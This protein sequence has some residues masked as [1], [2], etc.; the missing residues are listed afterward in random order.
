MRLQVQAWPK[1]RIRW[2]L[3]LALAFGALLGLMVWAASEHALAGAA[4]ALLV[5]GGFFLMATR[6]Y[7]RRRRLLAQP[8]PPDWREALERRVQFYARLDEAGRRRFEDD[9]RIFLNE[10]RI[11]GLRG[12]KVSD[13]SRVLIAA[14]AATMSHG[15]P[16][17]EWPTMRDI[18]VYPRRFDDEYRQEADAGILGMVHSQGPFLISER[19]LKEGFKRPNDGENVALHELAHV[20]DM[21]TGYA[22]GVPAGLSWSSSTPWVEAISKRLRRMRTRHRSVLRRYAA[23]NEAEFFAVAVEAF[24]EQPQRLKDRDPELYGLL[25]GYF[26]QDPCNSQVEVAAGSA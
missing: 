18:V 6:R 10:Q 13:E 19:D 3:G 9:V 8:F 14:A 2:S 23:T 22:D 25:S 4:A 7:R 11:Y 15:L 24:F 12:A 26:C 21:A 17:W 20:M 1:H 16:D 5:G